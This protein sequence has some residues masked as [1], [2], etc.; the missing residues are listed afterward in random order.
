MI[1][2]LAAAAP[3]AAQVYRC[4]NAYTDEPCRNGKVVDATP[5]VSDPAGPSSV[6]INLCSV[7]GGGRS[8][9]RDACSLKGWKLDRK[10]QVPIN[11]PWDE[12]VA[13]GNDKVRAA[14][15]YQWEPKPNYAPNPAHPVIARKQ[16]CKA[17]DARVAELD[18][19]G[20]AGSRVYS[21][22]WI[23][24][25]RRKARDQQFRLGC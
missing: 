18:Q 13:V 7:P 20:R 19:M 25:E 23:R 6:Y 2:L 14:E 12:Q 15:R 16:Q 3:A 4:G 10:V 1:A 17:L 22:E 9:S 24:E 8:W 11:L 21:L 5:A